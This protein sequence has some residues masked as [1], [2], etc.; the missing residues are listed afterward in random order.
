[1]IHISEIVGSELEGF[2]FKCWCHV[3][4]QIFDDRTAAELEG[5]VHVTIENL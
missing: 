5:S 3:E 4:G 1:M 2:W